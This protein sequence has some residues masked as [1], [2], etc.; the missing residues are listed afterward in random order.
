M[1]RQGIFR[2]GYPGLKFSSLSLTAVSSPQPS[3]FVQFN[4]NIR[5]FSVNARMDDLFLSFLEGVTPPNSTYP[6]V[7]SVPRSPA[8][9]RSV[10][11]L[12]HVCVGLFVTFMFKKIP[13]QISAQLIKAGSIK[14]VCARMHFQ[15]VCTHSV[16]LINRMHIQIGLLVSFR[17]LNCI[18]W[19]LLDFFF[20]Q[21][22]LLPS[23]PDQPHFKISVL[24]HSLQMAQVPASPPPPF[25]FV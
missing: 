25:F 19:F 7:Q 6:P 3:V 11:I 20:L 23:Y 13:Y 8:F 10:E 15:T 16:L 2:P 24:P 5:S 17:M 14:C 18:C 21:R 12:Q 9:C 4:P 22:S 1:E